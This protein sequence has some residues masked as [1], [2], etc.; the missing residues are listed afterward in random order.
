MKR[1]IF[2]GLVGVLMGGG[3]IVSAPTASAGCIDAQLLLFPGTPKCDGPILPDGSWRRCVVYS[4]P[5]GD[6]YSQPDCH[7]MGPNVEH[8][9]HPFYDPPTH[10]DP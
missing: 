3:L 4:A 7:L 2:A 5:P 9:V 10:I 8:I 6:P 1:Y